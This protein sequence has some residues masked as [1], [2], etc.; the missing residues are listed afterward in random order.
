MHQYESF[1]AV[2]DD[3]HGGISVFLKER[4]FGRLVFVY[5]SARV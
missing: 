2:L 1:A 4:R 3:L 5:T